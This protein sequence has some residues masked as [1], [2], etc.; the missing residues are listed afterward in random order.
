MRPSLR[1]VLVAGGV[2]A[3]LWLVPVLLPEESGVKFGIPYRVFFSL[4]TV[5]AGLVFYL[6]NAPPMAPFRSSRG[7]LGSVLLVLMVSISLIVLLALFAPQFTFEGSASAGTT[8][9]EKGK[10]LFNN[11]QAGCFLCHQ[12]GGSGGTRGPALDN[13]AIVAATR[14]PGLSVQDY[15]KESITNPGAFVSPRYDNIMPPSGDRLSPEEIDD[16]VAYLMTLK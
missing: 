1:I 15:L 10:A 12:V 2:I 5:F 9:Q 4:F 13:V 11:P 14:K 16:I 8:P 3:A 7:A 6:L